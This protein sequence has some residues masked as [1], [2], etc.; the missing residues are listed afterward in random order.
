MNDLEI[1][2]RLKAG[3]SEAFR[4]VVDRYQNMVMNCAYK[5]LQ[6]EESAEDITQDVF[7]EVF[8]SIGSFRVESKLSTWIYRITISKSLNFLKSAKRKKRF[9]ITIRLFG[10]ENVEDRVTGK[11]S[12]TPAGELEKKEMIAVLNLALDRLPENQ[13]VAFLLSKND[14]MSYEE[15]SEVMNLSISAVES[16]LHR[17]KVNLRR[18][19]FNYYKKNL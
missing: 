15:I 4:F 19:L 5:F 2:S 9:A 7:I 17:A 14:E 13:K 11:E 1:V 8:E 12:D 6:N 18:I 16:L 10:K 3:D